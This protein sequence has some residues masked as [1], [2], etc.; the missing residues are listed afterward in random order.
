[1]AKDAQDNSGGGFS[2][3]G[4]SDSWL[5]GVII[6]PVADVAKWREALSP[7]LSSAPSD[8]FHSAIAPPPWWPVPAAFD[9]CEYYFPKKLTGHSNGFVAISPSASAIY[10]S[11]HH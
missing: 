9:D 3:P 11:T 4:P 8:R 7:A 6:I 5:H 10:F 1:M 2:V